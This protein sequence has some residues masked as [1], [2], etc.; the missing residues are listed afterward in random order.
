LKEPDAWPGRVLYATFPRRLKGL[1]VDSMVLVA[2]LGAVAVATP[3]VQQFSALRVALVMLWWL[4]L[5]F[6]EPVTICLFGGT[7]GHRALNLRVVDNRT[8]R[9][10]SFGKALGRLVVKGVLG[11]FSFLTMAFTRRHQSVHDLLTNTSVRIRD[12]QR[13]Q[14]HQYTRV[15]T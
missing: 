1:T 12:P 11:I 5:I 14:P 15:R 8:G 9:N 6:Y 13:A 7:V 4:G 10:I 2:F 3:L